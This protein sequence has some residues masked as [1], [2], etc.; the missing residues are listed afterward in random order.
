MEVR[1]ECFFD[2][3]FWAAGREAGRRMMLSADTSK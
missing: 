1:L 3:N 2:Q